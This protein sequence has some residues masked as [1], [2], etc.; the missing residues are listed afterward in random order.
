MAEMDERH[1]PEPGMN[2][3]VDFLAAQAK[4]ALGAVNH[5]QTDAPVIDLLYAQYAIN[6][7]TIL[8]EKTAANATAPE[9][10]YLENILYEMRMLYLRVENAVKE[11]AKRAAEEQ[12]EE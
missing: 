4:M 7:L 1:F 5:P 9:K 2:A 8:E 12:T 6:L 3:L 11:A 10:N